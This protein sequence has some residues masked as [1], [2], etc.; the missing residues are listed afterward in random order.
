MK[1]E[2]RLEELAEAGWALIQR[3]ASSST[4]GCGTNTSG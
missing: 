1:P 4:G 2:S 3:K